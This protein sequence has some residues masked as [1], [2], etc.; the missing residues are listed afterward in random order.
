MVRCAAAPMPDKPAP[1]INT[2]TTVS[3]C[4]IS[5]SALSRKSY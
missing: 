3:A 4:A 5:L 2:S 1:T